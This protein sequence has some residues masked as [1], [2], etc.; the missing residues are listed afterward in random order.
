[1]VYIRNGER[2]SLVGRGGTFWLL[3][4]IRAERYFGTYRRTDADDDARITC[5]RSGCTVSVV[6]GHRTRDREVASSVPGQCIAG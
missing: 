2:W 4:S 1:M 5:K 6:V 3:L